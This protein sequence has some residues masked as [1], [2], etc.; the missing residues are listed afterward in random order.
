MP[1]SLVHRWAG[2][3]GA[4]RL[5][6]VYGMTEGLGFTALRGDEWMDHQGSV[7]RGVRETE[8]RILGA[9]GADL[10]PGEIGEI[11]LRSPMT[12]R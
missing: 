3:V 7:G 8:V 4:D 12:I 11:Y 5:V 1:P 2:L 6:M 10:P 9:D